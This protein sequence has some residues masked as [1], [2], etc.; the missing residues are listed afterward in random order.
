M[1]PQI[2]IHITS[3]TSTPVPQHID[4]VPVPLVYSH[5]I[6]IYCCSLIICYSYLLLL[7][8]FFLKL[9]CWLRACTVSKAVVF[10]VYDNKFVFSSDLFLNKFQTMNISIRV[11]LPVRRELATTDLRLALCLHNP[12]SLIS[13]LLDIIWESKRLS[14]RVRKRESLREWVRERK[15]ERERWE[16]KR[17]RG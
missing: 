17:Q 10:S 6:V 8:C 4:S 12:S 9:H 13:C 7:F 14:E 1:G 3:I 15:M 2:L 5:A 16:W 11:N